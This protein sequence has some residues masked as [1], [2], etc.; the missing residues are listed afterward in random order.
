MINIHKFLIQILL[1]IIINFINCSFTLCMIL[2]KNILN[3]L[4]FKLYLYYINTNDEK[5]NYGQC[6]ISQYRLTLLVITIT[7]CF[8]FLKC[9]QSETCIII[10]LYYD[11]KHVHNILL[12]VIIQDLCT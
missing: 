10:L 1:Y 4:I 6:L 7:N 5:I 8:F 12:C 9:N 11:I 3:I 2:L